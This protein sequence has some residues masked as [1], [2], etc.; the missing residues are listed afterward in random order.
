MST[1]KQARNFDDT[2]VGGAA[3]GDPAAPLLKRRQQ[4]LEM[5]WLVVASYCVDF[6]LMLALVAVDALSLNIP[7]AY[8]A[9]ALAVN[10]VFYFVLGS[11]WTE[12]FRDHY[13]ALPYMLAHSSVNLGFVMYAPEIGVLLIMV[14]FII[15]ASSALRMN[16]ARMLTGA[17]MTALIAGALIVEL[18][19]QFTLPT[20]TLAQRL[21]CGLWFALCLMRISL[22]GMFSA[23]L[24]D[25][26]AKRNKQLAE[27]FAKLDELAT[28]D[29]LTGVLNRR[30]IMQLLEEERQRLLRTGNAF[31]VALLDVDHFKHINDG[32]GHLVG[33]DV[34]RVFARNIGGNMRTT[35]RLGRYGGEE[36]LVLFTAT[37]H[38]D[39][40][41]QA[42]ERIR[43]GITEADWSKL[44]GGKPV[45]V[46]VGV[47]VC[48]RD[49]SAEQLLA[50]A[51]AALYRAKHEGR[52]CVRLGED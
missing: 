50:R 44:T 45:T 17:S 4:R 34:L 16:L 41:L 38:R 47:A 33:D 43:G 15:F 19:N 35:D 42:A 29:E 48:Q 24:R 28:R 3:D 8:G 31:A 25:T 36:F 6:L 1:S 9:T 20:A 49:E 2:L 7:L 5:F 10:V 23:K 11:G 21:V 26:I 22:L 12:R 14:Q 13:I 27:T 30:A 18:G 40:A 37:T 51:D 39:L 46:S 32:F 52:N